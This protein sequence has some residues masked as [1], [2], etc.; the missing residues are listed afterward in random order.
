MEPVTVDRPGL[1]FTFVT[2]A[3][4]HR[5]GERGGVVVAVTPVE[6]GSSRAVRGVGSL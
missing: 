3:G 6:P 1:S 2:V 4:P 5:A